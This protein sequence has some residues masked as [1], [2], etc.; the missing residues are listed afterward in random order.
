MGKN[1]GDWM[2]AVMVLAL[3]FLL[4]RPGSPARD[5]VDVFA[6]A[7]ISLVQTVTSV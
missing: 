2:A 5:A 7:F 4:V 3:V 1:A 6:G